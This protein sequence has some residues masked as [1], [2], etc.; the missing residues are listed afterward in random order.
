MKREAKATLSD[1]MLKFNALIGLK[2]IRQYALL[3][4]ASEI[5]QITTIGLSPINE[6]KR[7]GWVAVAPED[8]QASIL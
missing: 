6:I 5:S 4:V 7:I 2:R 3:M 8:Q 1:H